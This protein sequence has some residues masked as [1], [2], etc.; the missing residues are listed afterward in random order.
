M[1]E[2]EDFNP[3]QQKDNVLE[4][5]L[6]P[7]PDPSILSSSTASCE[8]PD[9]TSTGVWVDDV[10]RQ[11]TTKVDRIVFPRTE[12]EV[13]DL[14]QIA[15]REKKRVAIRGT[16]HSMGGHSVCSDAVLF[17][18]KYLARLDYNPE[19]NYASVGPG[20]QW[21]DVIRFLNTFGK[22]PRTM[23]SYCSFSVGGTLAVN[24][25]G[26]TSD[27][28]LIEDVVSFRLVR[29][30]FNE[31][32]QTVEV[33]TVVCQRPEPHQ[34]TSSDPHACSA[35]SKE[36]ELFRLAIGGYG[37]FGIV[38]EITLRVS[39]N[40]PLILDSMLLTHVTTGGPMLCLPTVMS[41]A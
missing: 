40:V 38:T 31:A 3:P 34:L 14:L 18:T 24:A 23:Q 26:I 6:W 15:L 2:L 33:E 27:S 8:S 39:D 22:S 21:S 4:G 10:S 30:D 20:C 32:N 25:H 17:D 36:K 11:S 1:G 41:Q 13:K 35:L 19:T 7:D 5:C 28:A 16:K 9:A 37:M 12:G 29:Y